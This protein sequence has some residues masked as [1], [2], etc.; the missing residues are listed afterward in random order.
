M[1]E[2][3]YWKRKLE[4]VAAEYQKWRVFYKQMVSFRTEIYYHNYGQWLVTSHK[5][6]LMMVYSP[7]SLK[8]KIERKLYLLQIYFCHLRDFGIFFFEL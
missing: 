3:K 7:K 2:G 1:V 8:L 4:V 5:H 6:E